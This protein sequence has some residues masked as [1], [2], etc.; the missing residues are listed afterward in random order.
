MKKLLIGI[1]CVIAT[2]VGWFLLSSSER[3][4]SKPSQ[5]KVAL[6]ADVFEHSKDSA[7]IDKKNVK[8]A[9]Q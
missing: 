2:I 6:E 3:Y 4:K 9:P 5:N 8:K 7:I 1:L